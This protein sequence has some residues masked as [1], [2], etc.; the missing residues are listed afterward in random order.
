MLSDL[1]NSVEKVQ[2]KV[3]ITVF[4]LRGWLDA[5]SEEDFVKWAS[6]AYEEGTRYLLLDLSELDTLTSGGMRAIQRAFKIYTTEGEEP[7]FAHLKMANAPP[8]VYHALKITGFLKSIPMYESVQSAI[9]SFKE[10]PA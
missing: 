3:P 7:E 6:E 5:Q 2:G 4:H 1:K 10:Q 8:P 9:E